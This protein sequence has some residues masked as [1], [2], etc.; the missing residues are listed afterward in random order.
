MAAI[1]WQNISGPSVAQA[2]VPL[3]DAQ[4]TLSGMFTGFEDIL[5]KRAAMENA[6]WDQTKVNNTNAFLNATQEAK[7]PEEFAAR[8]AMLREQLKGYGAQVDP[9]AARAALDGRMATLQQRGLATQQYTDQQAEV[10]GRSGV[11]G[12][13]SAISAIKTSADA[14]SLRESLG[15]ATGAGAIDPRASAVLMNKLRAAED[16]RLV[17]DRATTTFANQQAAEA[18]QVLLRPKAIL[19]AEDKLLDG[20]SRRAL[21]EAQTANFKAEAD[22]KAREALYG[23]KEE[24]QAQKD[25]FKAKHAASLMVN[26]AWDSTK[27]RKVIED[28][29]KAAGRSPGNVESLFDK[30]QT[31]YPNGIP[32]PVLDADGKPTGKFDYSPIPAELVLRAAGM[33]N[34]GFLSSWA[35]SFGGSVNDHLET[36]LENPGIKKEL[37][38]GYQAQLDYDTSGNNRGTATGS[39]EANIAALRN[40]LPKPAAVPLNAGGLRDTPLAAQ[41]RLKQAADLAALAEAQKKTVK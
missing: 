24:K 4:K 18:Q 34:T 8:E 26:G 7:T 35:S 5:T 9:M 3:G 10:A 38:D 13:D 40:A 14:Q 25:Y 1:T 37:K 19:E 31:K 12:Y 2:A 36:L 32:T 28:S 15:A 21:Q 23:S 22:V 30:V 16:S 6:N 27:G 20:P 29:L 11:A 33:T 17:A 39:T 41:L